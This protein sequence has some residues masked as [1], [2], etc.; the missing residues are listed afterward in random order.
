MELTPDEKAQ[1]SADGF[2]GP[3]DGVDAEALRGL[4]PT[5]QKILEGPVSPIYDRV[6][7]RDWHL[8]YRNL[9]TMVYQPAVIGRLQ[10][11]LGDNLLVWRS[12]I[13]HKAPGDGALGWHQSSLFAGEEYGLFKPALMP[14][15]TY[16]IWT[17]LFNVSVWFALDDVSA[18]NGA[19]QIA[20][21][22]HNRQYPIKKVPF[23]QSEFGRLFR[24]NLAR[25]GASARLDDLTQRYACE[26]IFDPAQSDAEIKTITMRAGQFF[27]FTDRVLHASLPNITPDRRRLA[28]NFRVTVPEVTV[29]PHRMHGDLIDGNDHCVEKHACIMLA[30]QDRYGKNIY[31]N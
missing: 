23:L 27:I 2:V 24:D 30:G 6:T 4:Q 19:M 22:T 14:P 16:E 11:I 26:T 1:F 15:E 25:S 3:F 17:D 20:A 12:S 18:D 31:F 8:H 5:F 10:S 13:F 9:M 28:I 29:Y 7:H 21:G